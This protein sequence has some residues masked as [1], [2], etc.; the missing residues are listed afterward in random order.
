MNG[1]EITP[2]DPE[3]QWLMAHFAA[4]EAKIKADAE[5]RAKKGN[6]ALEPAD[7]ANAALAFAPGFP[8]SDDLGSANLPFW[9][10]MG[11]SLTGVTLVS[12]GLAVCF[13]VI[14]YFAAHNSSL[15]GATGAWDIAKIFAGAVVGSTSA[16]VASKKP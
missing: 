13:G 7:L 5:S 12:G 2:R 3:E 10:R 4:L 6:R 14:G 15:V 1:N 11:L 16:A 8:F 9:R